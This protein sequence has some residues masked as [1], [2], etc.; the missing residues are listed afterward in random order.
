MGFLT[1]HVLLSVLSVASL[2]SFYLFVLW[3]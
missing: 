2:S 1:I 3:W